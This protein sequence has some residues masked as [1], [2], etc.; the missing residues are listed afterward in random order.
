MQLRIFFTCLIITATWIIGTDALVYHYFAGET[1]LRLQNLKGIFFVLA[2]SLVLSWYVQRE[3][4]LLNGDESRRFNTSVFFVSAIYSISWILITDALVEAIHPLQSQLAQSAKGLVYVLTWSLAMAWFAQ[5]EL[6]LHE[7]LFPLLKS[8]QLGLYTGMLVHEVKT[9]LTVLNLEVDLLRA[10]GQL[11]PEPAARL[12]RTIGSL[13]QTMQFF[14]RLARNEESNAEMMNQNIAL[15]PLIGEVV[16]LHERMYPNVQF[17]CELEPTMQ[18]RGSAGLLSHL[19]I[20]LLRNA[21]EHIE[22]NKIPQ[23]EISIRAQ[24]EGAMWILRVENSGQALS[25][26]EQRKLFQPKS[27]R[28]AVGGMGFGLLVAKT[29]A[30]AHGG[31]LK[32]DS[33]AKRPSFLMALPKA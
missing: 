8:S 28:L 31:E 6:L 27:T 1:A 23:A 25:E 12:L 9:P 13:D 15:R 24:L 4:R 2:S 18:V 20:N 29:I 26:P 11:A 33:K 5:R 22:E 10:Q 32:Y 30:E 16:S 3:I 19:F 14:A 21:A 17:K 7:R